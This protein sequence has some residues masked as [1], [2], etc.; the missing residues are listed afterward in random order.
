MDV[1]PVLPLVRQCAL[2]HSWSHYQNSELCCSRSRSESD[3]PPSCLVLR[4]IKSGWCWTKLCCGDVRVCSSGSSHPGGAL[5]MLCATRESSDIV[6]CVRCC[7]LALLGPVFTR[8]TWRTGS[9]FP[10]GLVLWNYH[11]SP[12]LSLWAPKVARWLLFLRG[13]LLHNGSGH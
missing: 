1:L 13:T 11:I 9:S 10:Y 2:K 5:A 6:G 4:E 7:P 8:L 3:S 12:R